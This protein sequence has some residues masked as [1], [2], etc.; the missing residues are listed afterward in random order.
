MMWL[1]FQYLSY[2]SNKTMGN[3]ILFLFLLLCIILADSEW[4]DGI[5]IKFTK[6][7]LSIG[8]TFIIIVSILLIEFCKKSIILYKMCIWTQR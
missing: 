4:T 5:G 2:K 1:F 7:I 8:E 3:K 6:G